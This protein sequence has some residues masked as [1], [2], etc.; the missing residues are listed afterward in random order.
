MSWTKFSSEKIGR[1]LY[2]RAQE[3]KYQL[4]LNCGDIVRIVG[5]Q[6]QWYM[7][8]YK[9]SDQKFYKKGEQSRKDI[10]GICKKMNN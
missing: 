2:S 3:D 5:E 6:Q 9:F 7:V 10:K 1:V 8:I 4:S